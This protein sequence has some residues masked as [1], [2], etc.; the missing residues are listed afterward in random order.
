MAIIDR[1]D[2]DTNLP[3][4]AIKRRLAK[5]C[6]ASQQGRDSESR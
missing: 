2:L 6:H 4:L 1:A 5:S 3:P